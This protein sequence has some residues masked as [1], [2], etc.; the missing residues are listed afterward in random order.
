M[1]KKKITKGVIANLK[2]SRYEETSVVLSG[3]RLKMREQAKTV[4]KSVDTG[5]CGLGP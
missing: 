5:G 3:D 4:N 2:R 1:K